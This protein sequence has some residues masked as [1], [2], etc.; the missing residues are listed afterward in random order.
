MFFFPGFVVRKIAAF[1]THFS[2]QATS[3]KSAYS[4]YNNKKKK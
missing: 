1:I 4:A 2:I 3:H